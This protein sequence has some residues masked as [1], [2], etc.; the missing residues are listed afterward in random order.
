[1]KNKDNPIYQRLHVFSAREAQYREN[2]QSAEGA[3]ERA[4]KE[5][6]ALSRRE[7]REAYRNLKNE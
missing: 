2:G 1:M 6:M 3:T 7:L 4:K 5:V